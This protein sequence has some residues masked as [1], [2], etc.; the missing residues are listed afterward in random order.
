MIIEVSLM[1][2]DRFTDKKEFDLKAIFI[3]DIFF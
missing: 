3:V 1:V 2:T